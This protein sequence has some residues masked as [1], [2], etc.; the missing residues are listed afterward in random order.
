[1]TDIA[2]IIYSHAV[3]NTLSFFTGNVTINYN[4]PGKM[5]ERQPNK[6]GVTVDPNQGFRHISCSAK[7]TS[8]EL[9]TLNTMMLPSSKPTYDTS[10]PKIEVKIDGSTTWT[11]YCVVTNVTLQHMA[12]NKWMVAIEFTER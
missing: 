6:V 3:T 1:M 7:L 11:I 8:T 10:Y 5:V 9:G 12:D 2:Q 4:F